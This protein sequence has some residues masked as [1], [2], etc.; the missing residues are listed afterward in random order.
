[1]NIRP[2][3]NQVLVQLLPADTQTD[4]GIVLPD[5]AQDT[6]RGERAVPVKATVVAVGHWRTTINGLS[7]LPDFKPGETVVVSQY[8]G[9]KLTRSL[10]A[11]YRLCRVD[12]VLAV[13]TDP[14]R[15]V[16]SIR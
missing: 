1:M 2:L 4:S 8:V 13:L 11:N 16:K 10:G 3:R 6:P 15:G 12:D 9:T 14:E 5:I 7:I